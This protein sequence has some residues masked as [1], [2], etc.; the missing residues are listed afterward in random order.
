MQTVSIQEK[1]FHLQFADSSHRCAYWS[2]SLYV[3]S[4]FL[5]CQIWLSKQGVSIRCKGRK[6]QI[7]FFF[8]CKA[9]TQ[10]ICRC[11]IT[12]NAYRTWCFTIA[13]SPFCV[14]S[15]GQ[16][17]N[18]VQGNLLW[19]RVELSLIVIWTICFLENSAKSEIFSISTKCFHL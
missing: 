16:V 14:V 10:N 18:L 19:T 3:T 17:K 12:E 2:V 13:K 7:C 11:T 8:R 1:M 15:K 6:Q 4:H 5:S 9:Y